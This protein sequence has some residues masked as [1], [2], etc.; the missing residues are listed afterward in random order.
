MAI[1]LPNSTESNNT[2]Y[3]NTGNSKKDFYSEYKK[4]D[5][6]YF[7]KYDNS[8]QY[9]VNFSQTKDSPIHRWFYYQEGYSPNLVIEMI[10][11][12]G[13][14]K[15]IQIFDPFAG[16]GTSLVAAK[17]LGVQSSIGIEINPLSYFIAKTK[18]QD[19]EEED[20]IIA[21]NFVVDYSTLIENVYDKYELSIIRKLF[22][23]VSLTKI[24]QIKAGIKQVSNI[25]SKDILMSAL[26]CIL[27][28]VSF[29]KKAGN[30]LKKKRNFIKKNIEIEFDSKL[31]TI[32]ED[33]RDL[34]GSGNHIVFNGDSISLQRYNIPEIDLSI[35]SPPYA[36]CFDYFEVYKIELWLGEFV[37]T[38]EELRKLR[39][40]ALK[41]NLSTINKVAIENKTITP[42]LRPIID[43]LKT[44]SLWDNKIPIMLISYFSDMETVLRNIYQVTKKGGF[45][46]I[47]VGNSS[48]GGLA[49]PTDILLAEISVS[50]G[51]QVQE[52][53]VARKNE[54]S[55]Q[56]YSSIGNLIEYV[57]ESIIILKK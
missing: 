3:I 42:S 11:Y 4:L 23:E 29:Y 25:K 18:V 50:V 22:D 48:Y 49:V 15:E 10:N 7:V 56:Q 27:Q 8:Y 21:E 16:S 34:K 51:F 38:Y 44:I 19:Y 12:L 14:S 9:L 20:F 53:I 6:K 28:D 39:K 36:N 24:E 26:L 2:S 47:V 30:G 54:T 35:F 31:K 5:K 46:I 57:R 1:K 52:I 13:L 40:S 41:S 37:K 33:L 17:E 45:T 32:I 43:Y 55:S